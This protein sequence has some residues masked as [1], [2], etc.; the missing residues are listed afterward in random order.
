MEFRLDDGQVALRD[1][2]A[3]YCADHFGVERAAEREGQPVDRARWRELGDLGIFGLVVPEAVGGIGLGAVE[4]AIVF[5]QLGIH[6]APGPFVWSTLAAAF[7]DGAA[8]GTAL[9]GGLE[10]ALERDRFVVATDPVL[11]EH[12]S[13]IDALLVLTTD[14]VTVVERAEL[15]AATPCTPFDPLTPVGRLASLPPGTRVGDADAAEQLRMLGTVLT[16]ALLLG[17]SDCALTVARD[18]ALEREQFDVPIGSFQAV[19]HILADMY[20][21]T[22]LARSA[23]YAAAAVYDDPGIDAPARAAAIAKL[24]AGEAALANAR[25]AVQVLGGM[26]F[27]WAMPPNYL[28]KRAWVLEQSFGTSDAHALALGSSIEEQRIAG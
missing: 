7:V 11:V 23:T 19:K 6:V 8:G 22:G 25:A 24:L 18:Y 2:I 16:A 27:T 1:T 13:D 17:V 20:V 28:L 15:P 3:R 4:A 12:A 26:G 9:V 10:Y 5:E 21:R 14:A